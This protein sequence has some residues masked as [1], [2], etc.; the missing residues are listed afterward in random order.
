[1][2]KLL[3]FTFAILTISFLSCSKDDEQGDSQTKEEIAKQNECEEAI[4]DAITNDSVACCVL[5]K[6]QA[7][8]GDTIEYTYNSSFTSKIYNWTIISGDITIIS[9]ENSK[10]VQVKFGDNFTGGEIVGLG[11]NQEGRKCSDSV[12]VTKK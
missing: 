9:G 8:P 1:M 2:K 11:D 7:S 10:T 5:G 4:N 3:I 12:E 6:L